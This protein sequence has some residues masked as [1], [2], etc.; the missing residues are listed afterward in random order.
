MA[1]VL[2]LICKQQ[3]GVYKLLFIHRTNTSE[4]GG[5]FIHMPGCLSLTIYRINKSITP[6]LQNLTDT[7]NMS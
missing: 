3:P 6:G 2:S 1:S 4:N 5:P 7:L